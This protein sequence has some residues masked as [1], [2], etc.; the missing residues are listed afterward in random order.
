[1]FRFRDNLGI[2][3]ILTVGLSYGLDKSEP[4]TSGKLNK[5]AGDILEEIYTARHKPLFDSLKSSETIAVVDQ[6]RTKLIDQHKQKLRDT[7]NLTKNEK[8]VIQAKLN[9]LE[10]LKTSDYLE[11]VNRQLKAE[12]G[13]DT[14]SVR[15]NSK[16]QLSVAGNLMTRTLPYERG[17]A[18]PKLFELLATK[19][20]KNANIRFGHTEQGI[21]GQD[22]AAIQNAVN[23][24]IN[25]KLV[26]ADLEQV[27][28]VKPV[29]DPVMAESIKVK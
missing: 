10:A 5:V 14:I 28:V 17:V 23:N 7:P 8:S 27:H 15:L 4:P 22:W 11:K 2:V 25:N 6:M 13:T 24:A 3:I 1:M 12:M 21:Q 9:K 26:P 20:G 16:N 19:T 29:V 18:D